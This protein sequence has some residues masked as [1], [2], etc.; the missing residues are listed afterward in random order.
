MIDKNELMKEEIAR[1]VE[2]VNSSTTEEEKQAYKDCVKD[3]M[4]A[5]AKKD[6]QLLDECQ[7]IIDE[8]Y[9]REDTFSR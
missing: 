7:K 4:M 8:N 2:L 9:E 6:W 3:L 1:Y 5:I